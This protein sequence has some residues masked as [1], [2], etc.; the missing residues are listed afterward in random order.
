MVICAFCDKK[1]TDQ[2]HGLWVCD[3]CHPTLAHYLWK[4]FGDVLLKALDDFENMDLG[5]ESN[6]CYFCG[7][8]V[9]E[10]FITQ[11]F[12]ALD[13][14]VVCPECRA[15]FLDILTQGGIIEEEHQ[16]CIFCVAKRPVPICVDHI[17]DIIV[18]V[19]IVDSFG[20]ECL[21]VPKTY[22]VK[23]R[24]EKVE[25]EPVELHDFVILEE[26]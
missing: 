19:V 20:H 15:K 4:R 8:K 12:P 14:Y 21:P 5:R 10:P 18:D 1:A 25:N 2:A 17:R 16:Y 24:I 7:K 26:V 13:A 22:S 11:E 23:C 9:I 3:H 6:C